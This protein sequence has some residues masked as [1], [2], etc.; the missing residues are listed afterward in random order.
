M[1]DVYAVTSSWDG[2]AG[3]LV[4]RYRGVADR[5]FPYDAAPDLGSPERR[6][7]WSEVAA[8]VRSA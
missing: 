7:R 6:E 5:V 1:L 2:L 8:K 4:D 3:A